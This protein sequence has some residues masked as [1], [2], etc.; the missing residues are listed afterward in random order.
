MPNHREVEDT[1][2]RQCIRRRYPQGKSKA[3]HY[4]DHTGRAIRDKATVQRLNSLRVPPAYQNVCY[5]SNPRAKLQVTARD[6]KGRRQ[7]RYSEAELRRSAG[8][9]FRRLLRFA[10][11][12]PAIRKSTTSALAGGGGS[13]SGG[14]AD[15]DSKAYNVD[16]AVRLLDQ[17][18]FRVGNPKYLKENKSYG[19]SNLEVGHVN[20]AKGEIAFQGKSGQQ[21]KCT[22]ADPQS[23]D[24][25]RQAT[26]KR[27]AKER[28]FGYATR[29]GRRA[30][31]RPLDINRRLQEYGKDISAKDFRTWHANVELLRH[32]AAE[33][34][35]RRRLG[36]GGDSKE[37]KT[38]TTQKESAAAVRR[39]VER[40]AVKLNHT[41][42][43]CRSNYLH[44]LVIEMFQQQPEEFR[45]AIA[46][47]RRLPA[48]AN[49]ARQLR[50]LEAIFY[51]MLQRFHR[52]G[53]Q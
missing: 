18:H 23:R 34:G 19:L 7:Y 44:P 3:P 21:N 17:C 46:P 4:V 33:A 10:K 31:I 51:G 53:S 41:P 50:S 11:L 43:V 45:T 27:S 39:A 49:D 26:R 15:L 29:Q 47:F 1:P 48:S 42:S 6:G 2:I 8:S 22:V 14:G 16:Q 9:K 37:K 25:L 20:A 13:G 36:A 40:T 5:E 52:S 28:L 24:F 35:G 30:E 32:L 38:T 12:L